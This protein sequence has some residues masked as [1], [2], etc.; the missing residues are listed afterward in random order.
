MSVQPQNT[1]TR[2]LDKVISDIQA[3]QPNNTRL[4]INSQYLYA[5]DYTNI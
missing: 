1:K 3:L 2:P 4:I 5:K